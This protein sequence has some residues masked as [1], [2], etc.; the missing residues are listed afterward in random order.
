VPKRILPFVLHMHVGTMSTTNNTMDDNNS[1]VVFSLGVKKKKTTKKPTKVS[2]KD[3]GHHPDRKEKGAGA[4]DDDEGQKTLITSFDPNDVKK[5]EKT[6]L[7][8][9]L[10]QPANA[11]ADRIQQELGKWRNN[12]N[13]ETR[14]DTG[15]SAA[16]IMKTEEAL[17][18][19]TSSSHA[20]QQQQQQR[21]PSSY[22]PHPVKSNSTIKDHLE[23]EMRLL[24]DQADDEAYEKI[25][26]D[27][28]GAALLR[29]MGW[30][31]ADDP[32]NQ[33]Q[34]ESNQMFGAIPRP[35]RLG[36][37][38]I[39]KAPGGTGELDLPSVLTGRN[40]HKNKKLSVQ[41]LSQQKEFEEKRELQRK[42]DKQQTMQLGSIIY[43]LE[44]QQEHP[45]NN[46]NN[47]DNNHK[48]STRRAKIVKL[49]GVPGLNMVLV[50]LEQQVEPTPVKK[51][52]LGP[53]VP[54]SEL[55]Q[56]PFFVLPK[57]P[58]PTTTASDSNH[59]RRRR[60][61]DDDRDTTS[62]EVRR[63]RDTTRQND[64]DRKDRRH[65]RDRSSRSPDRY[66]NNSDHDDD[67]GRKGD[68]RR[69]RR[70]RDRDKE[71]RDTRKSSK[72]QNRD[73]RKRR[74]DDDRN[75][76][77]RRRDGSGSDTESDSDRRDKQRRKD[78]STRRDDDRN[79]KRSK[80]SSNNTHERKR[81]SSDNNL[82]QWVIPN[83]R[84]RVVT[85]KLG[86][87]HFRQKGVI[88]DVNRHH[89][90]TLRMDM[91]EGGKHAV[92]EHVP[93]Q[94]L[95]TALPKS[96][97][98]AICLTGPHK[99]TKGRLLERNSKTSTGSIQVFEDMSILTL[100][101]DDIAEWCGPLD[102]DLG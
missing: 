26:I 39:P 100:S 69:D 1:K 77:R 8:I 35:S 84:V 34:Q 24:P 61:D 18:P 52:Q 31:E 59:R 30:Q 11:L 36:L 25:P 62:R 56:Q 97:G 33:K 83:I 47:H 43:L 73:D 58:Q 54:R 85:E 96:G 29:G 89:G 2:A 50:H 92:L 32:T 28:F 71:D 67:D 21:P 91:L 74:N 60:D 86:K 93:E 64:R 17:E 95:E 37:G 78:S 3:F 9:P 48:G 75:G 68:R 80:K 99:W 42:Q 38:A 90:A 20:Q 44:Q 87:Q 10:T 40:K 19:V 65:P 46:N 16:G 23:Q 14:T 41:Q 22:H 70:D 5:N 45:N 12:N 27:Q 6:P 49:S 79:R 101:L 53:L 94:Y 98:H 63:D 15:S 4:E 88:V 82:L 55:E 57:K 7:V 72:D 13:E 66:Y 51:G 102:D 81:D 76:K